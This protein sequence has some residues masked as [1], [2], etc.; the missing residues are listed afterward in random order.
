M[1]KGGA[2][3]YRKSRIVIICLL[4]AASLAA[5]GYVIY[6]KTVKDYI[7]CARMLSKVYHEDRSDLSFKVTIDT[8]GQ[9]V[10]SQF[11][12]VRFPYQDSTA[13]QITIS[14][15]NRDYVFY[16]VRGKN[17]SEQEDADAQ[18]GIPKNFMELIEWGREIYSSD[19]EIRKT[20]DRDL[21]TYTVRVPDEMVQTFMDAYLGK[22]QSLELHYTD[23]V[24]VLSGHGRTMN[25]LTLQGTAEY[26]I[27][28][29]NAS[30]NIM[31]R[32]RVNALGD[33]VAVP[34]IPDYV[35]KAAN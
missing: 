20:R 34:D 1:E 35:V 11:R 10:D 27:L 26:R 13:T 15:K 2:V 19:L 33:K 21:A 16:K 17:V 30:T 9:T 5:A 7:D 6:R 23:C 31:V 12:A 32:A 25:E 18:N 4:I 24:L 3:M 14:G 22:L 8:A 29:V 28:F